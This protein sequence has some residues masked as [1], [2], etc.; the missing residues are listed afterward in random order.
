MDD[1]GEKLVER[2]RSGDPEA[3][4]DMVR[5]FGPRLFSYL[6]GRLKSREA[7]EDAYAEVW[8]RVWK[9]LASYQSLGK[10]QP[11]LF[12]IAHRLS[13]D[14]LEREAG[15]A[16]VSID[17][18]PDEEGLPLS[19]RWPSG[20]PGPEREAMG[21]QAW[22]KVS[23]VLES[24]P[25]EQRQV[26]L[27]REFGGLSFA[28]IAAAMDCPLGTALARMRYAVLKLRQELEGFHA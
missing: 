11:W 7:A 4:K 20:E 5:S 24:L 19:E 27:L 9:G 2:A 13:L 21:R 15:R 23:A 16:S 18:A 8:M 10:F 14:L 22:E 25:E 12:T 17:A 26:F 1:L 28:E 3:F 6:A